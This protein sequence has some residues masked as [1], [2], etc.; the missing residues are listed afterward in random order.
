MNAPDYV[1]E[2]LVHDAW[3]AAF[4]LPRRANDFTYHFHTGH[5]RKLEQDPNSLSPVLRDAI[6]RLLAFVERDELVRR[7]VV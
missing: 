5:L 7:M 4:V 3:C 1:H 2:M 6:E